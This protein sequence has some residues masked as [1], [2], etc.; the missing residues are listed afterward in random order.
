[1]PQ[2]PLV[3]TGLRLELFVYS[4]AGAIRSLWTGWR[5]QSH[6]DW[7]P[8]LWWPSTS[9]SPLY[10]DGDTGHF[11]LKLQC[12]G[13]EGEEGQTAILSCLAGKTVKFG[14]FL[15]PEIYHFQS[16]LHTASQCDFSRMQTRSVIPFLKIFQWLAIWY[17]VK[18]LSPN[19][20]SP[21]FLK[22][23]FW[24]DA[25]LQEWRPYFPTSLAA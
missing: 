20:D 11:L 21:F 4:E 8:Y 10:Q 25:K 16:F 1:M 15:R 17:R 7:S 5:N 23:S 3:D 9:G 6:L 18:L 24:L 22:N 12:G 19:I 2:V 13:R 14:P